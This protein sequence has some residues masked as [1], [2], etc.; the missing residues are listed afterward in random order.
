[1]TKRKREIKKLISEWKPAFRNVV[2]DEFKVRPWCRVTHKSTLTHT[3]TLEWGWSDGIWKLLIEPIYKLQSTIV[4]S[5][6]KHCNQSAVT[7]LNTKVYIV[8]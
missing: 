1:M 7:L 2:I 6:I 3:T 8:F 5:N 4:A